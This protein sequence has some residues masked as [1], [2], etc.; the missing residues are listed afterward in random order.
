M[1][2]TF[3]PEI[4]SITPTSEASVL[5]GFRSATIRFSESLA[6]KTVS[7]ETFKL[8]QLD[9]GSEI[10]IDVQL[11]NNDQLVQLSFSELPLGSYELVIESDEITDRAGN[12]LGANT[13]TSKFTIEEATNL[14]TTNLTQLTPEL[15]AQTIVGEGITIDNVKFT[16][17]DEAAGAFVGGLSTGINISKGIILSSGN[18]ANAIGPNTEDDSSTA[19]FTPGDSDLNELIP[20]P[21]NDAVSLEFDFTPEQSEVSFQYVFASEEYNEFVG[22]FNDIF[23]FFIDGENVALVP[24]TNQSVAINNVN[25]DTNS[26][27]YNNN[28]PGDLGIPTPFNFG[29]DG[30]TT[31]L[32]A[33]AELEA[34]IPHNIK[35]VIG[36]ANDSAL[37]SAVFLAASSLSGG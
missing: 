11:R 22:E 30:F 24:N 20:Q 28:D 12:I 31:V 37:D 1:P 10:P 35:L 17:A 34:S 6:V 5:E 27:F 21:T 15:L 33:S 25:E 23:A 14:V 16:G 29:F 32:T 18:I 36:D 8:F 7:T 13:F 9:S 3:E 2:D 19:F 4:I 26:Q